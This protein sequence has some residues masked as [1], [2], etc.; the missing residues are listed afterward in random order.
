MSTLRS[1][2]RRA[3]WARICLRACALCAAALGFLLLRRLFGITCLFKFVTGI[4]C[5]TCGMSGAVLALLEGD[6]SGSLASNAFALPVGALIFSF[7]FPELW[8]QKP[9]L[10]A[11]TLIL[12]GN[13]AYYIARMALGVI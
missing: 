12:A 4:S 6:F 9:F 10:C 5:P 7:I 11:A 13:L 8:K 2:E 3:R 1:L